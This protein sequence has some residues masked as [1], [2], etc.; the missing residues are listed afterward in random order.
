ME[1]NN[2]MTS[3]RAENEMDKILEERLLHAKYEYAMAMFCAAEL[4]RETKQAWWNALLAAF[5]VYWRNCRAFLKGDDGQNSIKARHY[6]ERFEASSLAHLIKEAGAID[7]EVAHLGHKRK[8]EDAKKFGLEG[9]RKLMDW[10][11]ENFD[12]F[13]AEL[14]EPYRSTWLRQEVANQ[15]GEKLHAT[16]HIQ[17]INNSS[18]F[19]GM[20]VVEFFYR[21]P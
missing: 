17:I 6:I 7:P 4:E 19:A 12:K 5:V 10:L 13:E 15:S 9:A 16:N 14:K 8:S 20:Q 21:K 2:Y 11:V 3:F 18:I 1:S